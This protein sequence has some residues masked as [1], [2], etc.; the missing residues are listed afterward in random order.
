LK[1]GTC[2]KCGSTDIHSG[3]DILF[4]SGPFNCNSIP[5]SMTSMA[6]LDNYVCTQCGLV[7]RYVAE[8]SKLKEI[9]RKWPR[10]EWE[11]AAFDE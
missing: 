4:K 1:N 7:E 11:T 6:A 9:A 3:E 10:V 2:P 5:V 8:P